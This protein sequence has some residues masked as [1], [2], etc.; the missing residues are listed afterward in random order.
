ME[1]LGDMIDEYGGIDG[2]LAA[3]KIAYPCRMRR[4]IL[5]GAGLLLAVLLAGCA[6]ENNV[7]KTPVP[8]APPKA[9]Q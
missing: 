7:T 1:S 2:G 9:A 3:R 6:E 5:I 8:P 4:V